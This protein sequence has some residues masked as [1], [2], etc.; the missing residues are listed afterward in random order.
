LNNNKTINQIKFSSQEQKK[1]SPENKK[2]SNKS[3][4][5]SFSELISMCA[6]KKEIMLKYELE[7]NVNLISFKNNN[8]EISFNENLNKDF[9]KNLTSKLLEWTGERWIIMLSKKLG[10]KTM[11]ET[12]TQGKKNELED[13]RNSNT[14][15]KAIDLFPDL[16]I[17]NI[18]NLEEDSNE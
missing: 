15:K 6:F 3:K 13:I 9:I 2:I 7:N 4:I 10:S 5:N 11:K 12:K 14:Y 17:I 1:I 18:K 16:E 8:I